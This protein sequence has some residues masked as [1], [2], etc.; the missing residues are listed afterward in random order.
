MTS[1]PGAP[2][3]LVSVVDFGFGS[4]GKLSSI[5]DYL[6]ECEF[7]WLGASQGQRILDRGRFSAWYE[8]LESTPLSVILA[9]HD[10]RGALV[11]LD[12]EMAV[13]IE[14]AGIPVV[15]VDSLPHLW[16]ENDAVASEVA[17]YC[18]QTSPSIPASAWPPLRR[19]THLRWVE[20]IVPAVPGCLNPDPGG[21]RAVVNL[22]GLQSPGAP[23]AGTP[24]V[25]LV[26]PAA[27]SALVE[28]GYE[29]VQ[30]TGNL[31]DA[32]D[33]VVEGVSVTQRCVPHGEMQELMS[34]ANLVLTSPG[35]T[36]ALELG[37]T[38]ADVVFLPPQNVSQ[39]LLSRMLRDLC[40]SECVVTWPDTALGTAAFDAARNQGELAALRVVYDSIESLAGQADGHEVMR[41][42]IS[43]AVKAPCGHDSSRLLLETMGSRGAAQAA[44]LVRQLTAEPG[45]GRG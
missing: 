1:R 14:G 28:A 31:P 15:F 23:A 17:C 13:T 18:A 19:I 2:A 16:T 42:R 27:L 29:S 9:A 43:R 30:V 8:D 36:T 41:D 24:Y 39:V 40:S 35:L 44:E 4:A 11:I 12:H 26:L 34:A 37:A 21:K 25:R 45:P 10:I 7:I 6:P 3:I 5:M 20:G 32:G 38:A 22:G 33:R